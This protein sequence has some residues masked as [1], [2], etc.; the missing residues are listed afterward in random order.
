V[1]GAAGFVVDGDAGVLVVDDR[2][3]GGL[4]EHVAGERDDF[5]AR[6]HDLADG[7][8]VHFEGAV[9]EALLKRGQD[10]HAAGGGGDE[11]ELLRRMDGSSWLR[12][13]W[14]R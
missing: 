14:K 2:G 7:D 4:D 3:A 1:L 11:L 8:F 5:L 13:T 9:D 6:G 10:A 12:G